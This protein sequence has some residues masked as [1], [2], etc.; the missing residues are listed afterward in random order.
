MR[1]LGLGLLILGLVILG[2]AGGGVQAAPDPVERADAIVRRAMTEQHIPGL[3]IAVVKDGEIVMSRAYGVADLANK[4]PVTPATIF[5]I[6]S[7]TKAFTGVAAMREVE[8]GRL[9]LAKPIGDYVSGLPE[10]WRAIEVRRLLSN[11]SGLPNFNSADPDGEAA[12]AATL[13]SPVQFPPGQRFEYNQ[14][15]YALVQLAINGL[16]GRAPDAGLAGEQIALAGMS[17]TGW[18]DARDAGPG[19]TVSYGFR[20]ATPDQPSVRTEI[21]STRHHAASGMIS[22]AA[23]MARWMI[24]LQGDALLTP[25]AKQTMWTPVAYSDGKAGQWGMGWLVL[26][27]PAHRAVAMTGGSRSAVYLYPDDKVGVVILTNLAGSTPED[28]IDEIAQGF[29][30]GMTLTGVPALRAALAG[31]EGADP[32]AA[33]AVFRAA[34]PGFTAD[35]HE[36]N[37]WGYRLMAFGKPRSALAVLKLTAELYP[38]SGNAFDSLGEAYAANGDSAS[39][40]TA[41]SKS[42]ALDPANSNAVQRLEKLK[43]QP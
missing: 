20:R 22:T 41:Y 3:Q 38:A 17:R 19:R 1:V 30:P 21:F 42:L 7:I 23:D 26:D 9:D 27:R 2:L 33:V 12:W 28:L 39:A 43:K 4:T 29:I 32:A 13:A 15:N 34:N 18:G 14:T 37:D 24:A 10:A 6:N 36:L 40:V 35:E 5:P 25:A 31:R 8:A 11:T 16:R